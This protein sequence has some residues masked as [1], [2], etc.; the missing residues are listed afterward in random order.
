[1]DIHTWIYTI[2]ILIVLSIIWALPE[3]ASY[4]ATTVVLSQFALIYYYAEKLSRAK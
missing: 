2:C 4:T 1:M 3:I